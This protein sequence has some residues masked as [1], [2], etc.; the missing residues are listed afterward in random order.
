MPT[1]RVL[2]VLLGYLWDQG[3]AG[4][5]ILGCA[6]LYFVLGVAAC[7]RPLSRRTP[8][9]AGLVGVAGLGT[10]GGGLALVIA[11]RRDV[12]ACALAAAPRA[13]LEAW[14]FERA[15]AT[16]E[17]ALVLL[18]LGLLWSAVFGCVAVARSARRRP[19]GAAPP[20]A[21]LT[22]VLVFSGLLGGLL[23]ARAAGVVPAM[24]DNTS[25]AVRGMIE[26][27]EAARRQVAV[28]IVSG[29]VIAGGLA[30]LLAW[31]ADG[32]GAPPPRIG[33]KICCA[34]LLVTGLLAFART[35][36]HAED[37]AARLPT[38][39]MVS[40]QT[41]EGEAYSRAL[42]QLGRCGDWGSQPYAPSLEIRGS[43][44]D[45]DGLPVADPAELARRLRDRRTV[46]RE[47]L[48][49]PPGPLMLSASRETAVP[50]MVPYLRALQE[51]WPE[52]LSIVAVLP[53]ETWESRTLGTFART[54]RTCRVPVSWDRA[55]R[56]M[57]SLPSWQDVA[58]EAAAEPGVGWSP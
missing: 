32:E 27:A 4:P 44:V 46:Y 3:F 52:G 47:V 8:V 9:L 51:V 31:R 21:A 5:V 25:D 19:A 41:P 34:G 18:G 50:E 30:A 11:S 54:P 6:A 29:V 23:L 13:K 58:R 16:G 56:S 40:F 12:L 28:A 35:R 15:V 33:E 17:G 14:A 48:A 10:L 43:A 1:A 26:A 37:T 55:G 2:E 38:E 57:S 24:A 45:V 39:G 22:S 49:R 42:P 53:M 36:P 20:S 7:A